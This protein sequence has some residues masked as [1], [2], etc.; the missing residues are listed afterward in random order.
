MFFLENISYNRFLFYF[1][2]IFVYFFVYRSFHAITEEVCVSICMV[3]FLCLLLYYMTGSG[4]QAFQK[5]WYFRFLE[6]L[7]VTI[8][9]L[10]TLHGVF[11]FMFSNKVDFRSDFLD[12]Y[13][14]F[15]SFFKKNIFSF[16][17]NNV[18]SLDSYHK[19]VFLFK[20]KG[21]SSKKSVDFSGSSVYL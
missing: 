18:M 16:F 1:Y 4:L 5:S 21:Q 9:S 17:L 12:F 6:K 8:L 10:V 3:G 20:D 15:L 19:Q 13:I 11:S 7:D 14:Y 2:F